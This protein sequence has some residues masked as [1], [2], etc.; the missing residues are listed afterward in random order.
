MTASKHVED[1]TGA[2]LTNYSLLYTA[3]QCDPLPPIENGFNVYNPDNVP[4]YDLGTVATYDCNAGFFLDFTVGTEMRTYVDD[5]DNDAEGIFD[6]R[7]QFVS[8]SQ[9]TAIRGVVV[10]K[11][12]VM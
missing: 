8:V 11:N 12:L 10:N 4:P 3:I 7:H 6:A 9:E 5:G 2:S 1:I